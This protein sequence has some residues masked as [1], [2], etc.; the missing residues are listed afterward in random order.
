MIQRVTPVYDR[1]IINRLRHLTPQSTYNPLL[2]S[3]RGKV[4]EW[5]DSLPDEARLFMVSDSWVAEENLG[6]S[7]LLRSFYGI[8]KEVG[9]PVEWWAFDVADDESGQA[10]HQA[11]FD[12]YVGMKGEKVADLRNNCLGY[13]D[14]LS[15]GAKELFEQAKMQDGDQVLLL[16]INVI[17]LAKYLR[18]LSFEPSLVA[19]NFRVGASNANRVCQDTM[20][21][22]RALGIYD[23]LDFIQHLHQYAITDPQREVSIGGFCNFADFHNTPIEEERAWA[24]LS[25]VLSSGR[26]VSSFSDF[27]SIE[28]LHTV[29][30]MISD[31]DK[32]SLP[33]RYRRMYFAGARIDKAKNFDLILR[34]YLAAFREDPIA[35]RGIPLVLLMP[36]P[37]HYNNAVEM[38][39]IK[40][41]VEE[42]F[43]IYNS[44]TEEERVNVFIYFVPPEIDGEPA[45]RVFNEALQNIATVQINVSS[46]EGLPNAVFDAMFHKK[47]P[48]VSAVGGMVDQV[49]DGVSGFVVRKNSVEELSFLFVDLAIREDLE[50]IGANAYRKLVSKFHPLSYVDRFM[51]LVLERMGKPRASKLVFPD[52]DF[53]VQPEQV[54]GIAT[55]VNKILEL[56]ESTRKRYGQDFALVLTLL[57]IYGEDS[58]QISLELETLR[59]GVLMPLVQSLGDD[60]SE[61]SFGDKIC[62]VRDFLGLSYKEAFD[63]NFLPP[64]ESII[65]TA[66][67]EGPLGDCNNLSL[68]FFIMCKAVGIPVNYYTDIYHSFLSVSDDNKEVPV[69]LAYSDDIVDTYYEVNDKGVVAKDSRRQ[70]RQLTNRQILAL[71]LCRHATE[72]TTGQEKK[73]LMFE[74]VRTI[75]P[76]FAEVHNNLGDIHFAHGEYQEALNCYERAIEREEYN[77][78][79]KLNRL[80][81]MYVLNQNINERILLDG[82]DDIFDIYPIFA[83]AFYF[84]YLIM[85]NEEDRLEAEKRGYKIRPQLG[86]CRE[87]EPKIN[88]IESIS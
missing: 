39:A 84:R 7:L 41:V 74:A 6:G 80:L 28:D 33:P 3:V 54:A 18:R 60:F 62:K 65:K 77:I 42:L 5:K 55:D 85:G 66:E 35:M 12:L 19:E 69:D 70:A 2:E 81:T 67:H 43:E 83:E 63:S 52:Q 71:F 64:G 9:M 86:Y 79:F 38:E 24:N 82:L 22:F 72:H 14:A 17:G 61:L 27:A 25:W 34:S 23:A 36:S 31:Q 20:E 76:S 37:S 8:L 50:Q 21:L 26:T 44:L 49:E 4:A 78:F 15:L 46:A 57:A 1:L 11:C 48:V 16:D 47:V 68:V 13:E 51:G 73:R 45:N 10:Y 56:F 88:F 58:E 59:E 75:D 53:V 87:I 29:P 30:I 40:P 32:P